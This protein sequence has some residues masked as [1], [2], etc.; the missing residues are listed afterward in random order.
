[1]LVFVFL[2]LFIVLG[3]A[4]PVYLHLIEHGQISVL[5][6][7]LAFFLVLNVLICFWE[8]GLG[9]HISTIKSE[10]K[11]LSDQYGKQRLKA[12][13]DLM[14][15]PLQLTDIVSLL[16]WSRIWSTYSLYDPSYSNKESFGFFV[17]VG[18]GWTTLVPS[19]LFLYSMTYHELIGA[20]VLGMIGLVK[21]Y[22]EFYGTCIYFLSFF[23]N[24]RHVG[25]SAFEVAMFVGFSNGLWFVFPLIGMIASFTLIETNS[26]AIFH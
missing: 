8:I 3:T 1:M 20:R 24:K 7:L 13:V 4:G 5:Q 26:Y 23:F 19:L 25:K 12:V 21:F 22:Q 18:N 6:P 14:N 2:I 15:Y 17:D 11:K 16:F 9:L 10:Y